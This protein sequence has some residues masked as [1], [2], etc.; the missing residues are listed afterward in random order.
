II[1]FNNTS[2]PKNK[3]NNSTNSNGSKGAPLR[4]HAVL[5][6]QGDNDPDFVLA[7]TE[8]EQVIAKYKKIVNNLKERLM[9][10]L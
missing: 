7:I 6:E 2:T 8:N 1:K 10:S 3:L 9:L 5:R 4:F